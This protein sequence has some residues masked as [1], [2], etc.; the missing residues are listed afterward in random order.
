[1]SLDFF[2]CGLSCQLQANFFDDCYYC[3]SLV[4]NAEKGLSEE[5]YLK[6]KKCFYSSLKPIY[7]NDGYEKWLVSLNDIQ[8]DDY[9]I[10]DS[11]FYI[12]RDLCKRMNNGSLNVKS[13]TAIILKDGIYYTKQSKA[14]QKEL[15][16]SFYDAV[17]GVTR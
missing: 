9:S 5:K 7:G 15:F 14:K 2:Y 4:H 1:M 17:I 10:F 11:N 13:D 8:K 3:L 12:S 6:L 16:C